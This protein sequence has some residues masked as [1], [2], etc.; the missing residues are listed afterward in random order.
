M[1]SNPSFGRGR[2]PLDKTSKQVGVSSTC[3]SAEGVVF[4]KGLLVGQ[5]ILE[6]I[7]GVLMH[8][9]FP[10]DFGGS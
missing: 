10:A 9:A 1:G 5:K 3:D 2:C 8:A 7:L 4:L 6:K